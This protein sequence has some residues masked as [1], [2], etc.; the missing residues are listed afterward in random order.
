MN[1]HRSFCKTNLQDYKPYPYLIDQIDLQFDLDFKV[2]RVT[3]TMYVE[4]KAEFENCTNIILYGEEIKLLSISINDICLNKSQYIIKENILIIKEIPCKSF[5]KIAS[6][7]FP[8]KNFSMI[9]LYISNGNFFTQ[10]EPEGFRRITWFADRPDVMSRYT[11]TVRA[12]KKYSI[13][14]SNGNLLYKKDISNNITEAKW[15]DPFPKPSY[16]FALVVGN[17]NIRERSIKTI[18]GRNIKLQIYSEESICYTEWAMQ[19]LINAIRWDEKK[20]N[21]ELDLDRFMLV[22]VRDFNMGAM[23]NKGL[24]IFNSSYILSSHETSTDYDY[25]NIESTIAHEYFHNWTGNRVTCRDWFQLSLK[26]GLTVFREQEFT[27]DMVSKNLNGDMS[28]SAR[29]IKRIDDVIYLRSNQFPEDSG[30][31]AHPVR[32]DNYKEI[33]NFYTPTIYEKGAEIIR[34]Q[35][36]LLGTEGFRAAMDKYFQLYDGMAVTCED[37]INIVESIYYSKN[38]NSTN[39]KNFKNWYTQAGTPTVIVKMDYKHESKSCTITLSQYCNNVGSEKE[40]NKEKEPFFIPFSISILDKNGNPYKIF[41]KDKNLSIDGETIT[42]K[43]FQKKQ[44]WIFEEISDL[45]VLSLL[46]NFSAPVKVKYEYK[47]NDLKIIALHDNDYFAKWEAVQELSIAQVFSILDQ[48]N[49]GLD[50]QINSD[51][52]YIYNKIINNKN[53]YC[54]YK[55]KILTIPNEKTIAERLPIINPSAIAIARDLLIRKI[56]EYLLPLWENTFVDNQD[57][58]NTYSIDLY[59]KRMLKNLSARYI[60][61]SNTSDMFNIFEK[62]FYKSKNMTN[63]IE[64][65]SNIIDFGDSNISNELLSFFYNKWYKNSYVMDK[66]FSVQAASRKKNLND[67]KELMSNKYF[68]FKNP[69]R[70][71]SLI[72][73]FCINNAR[74]M[75]NADGSGYN[76]WSEQVIV[77]DSLNQELSSSLVRVLDNWSSLIPNLKDKAQTSLLEIYNKRD[78]SRNVLEIVEKSLTIK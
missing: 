31:M 3:N 68:T 66:W 45:P 13:L 39:F 20:Y 27:S 7:C 33:S 26:E 6:E 63:C 18:S 69:N 34:M 56:G 48:I 19:S 76:F 9:G 40:E 50:I 15:I 8:N 22:A 11:V 55:A 75:H 5:I 23:E 30:P 78:I 1:N 24:N 65:L 49:C 58:D 21:L 42:L 41:S 73:Q 71:R 2:T 47:N 74:G 16:L 35:H 62:H 28:I 53:L 17:F 4:R 54:G 72:F 67:I 51:L 61:A 60:M 36:N 52:I 29:A 25:N 77:L 57:C 59:H 10:C 43:F 12:N 64:L 44:K 37:F 46:R 14:L 38:H 70:V 32:P